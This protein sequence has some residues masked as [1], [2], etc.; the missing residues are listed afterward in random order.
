MHKPSGNIFNYTY[1]LSNKISVCDLN[2]LSVAKNLPASHSPAYVCLLFCLSL[3]SC[4][5][6]LWIEI[7][8][9][10]VSVAHADTRPQPHTHSCSFWYFQK[11]LTSPTTWASSSVTHCFTDTR[12]SGTSCCPHP[13]CSRW[14]VPHQQGHPS[15]NICLHRARTE[16]EDQDMTPEWNPGR[17]TA[18]V[19]DWEKQ[20]KQRAAA[21]RAN[22][23]V[24]RISPDAIY[25]RFLW[26]QCNL[27]LM[28]C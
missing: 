25:I 19:S 5:D 2:H 16:R 24:C 22:L 8:S 6:F 7:D 15:T 17:D 13:V 23:K 20:P 28:I 27:F 4:A 10:S 18:V 1:S 9:L 14:L 26:K 11:A 12:L 21:Q 3:D